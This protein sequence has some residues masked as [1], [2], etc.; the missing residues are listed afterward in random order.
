MN[1]SVFVWL[2]NHVFLQF[3]ICL[4]DEFGIAGQDLYCVLRNR[5]AARL[6]V[7][8]L[9]I[10]EALGR[11][12]RNRC[13][14]LCTL[15]VWKLCQIVIDCVLECARLCAWMCA[16]MILLVRWNARGRTL[17][18]ARLRVGLCGLVL[19]YAGLC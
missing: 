5:V 18:C 6:D 10:S 14:G 16:G 7:V 2:D 1:G 17:I 11:R 12:V 4:H 13:Q 19:D 8:V 15:A 3:L 9:A